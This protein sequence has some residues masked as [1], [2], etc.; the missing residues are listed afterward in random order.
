VTEEHKNWHLEI[1]LTYLQHLKEGNN[2]LGSTVIE[3]EMWANHHFTFQ[4]K[5]A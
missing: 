1:A 4:T 3:D 5:Q 2:F